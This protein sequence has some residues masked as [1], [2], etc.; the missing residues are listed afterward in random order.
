MSVGGS[1]GLL[2][3]STKKGNLDRKQKNG[4]DVSLSS[5][6]KGKGKATGMN[7]GSGISTNTSML[8][9]SSVGVAGKKGQSTHD[10]LLSVLNGEKEGKKE[11]VPLAWGMKA[12]SS[13]LTSSAQTQ[14]V[15]KKQDDGYSN[16]NRISND[17]SANASA[18]ASATSLG[19]GSGKS[20][21]TKI[22]Q[23]SSPKKEK[24]QSQSQLVSRSQIYDNGHVALK[25]SNGDG[26]GMRMQIKSGSSSTSIPASASASASTSI[27]NNAP[28]LVTEPVSMP[29]KAPTPSK[30]MST[31]LSSSLPHTYSNSKINANSNANG[32]TDHSNVN[33]NPPKEDQVEF[34][35]K[36]AKERAEKH[37]V[38]EERRVLAQKERA[39]L[40]LKE[41]EL[42]MKVHVQ[43]KDTLVSASP[44]SS[45]PSSQKVKLQSET[46]TQPQIKIQK[47]LYDP[48]RPYS[49]LVGGGGANNINPGNANAST[50]HSSAVPSAS[51]IVENDVSN[52]DFIGVSN[53]SAAP[54][55]IHINN[56][57]DRDRGSRSNAG[58]RML[59]DPKSGSMVAA[60]GAREKKITK[61]KTGR[62]TVTN[63][64][65][66]SERRNG[67]GY[68]NTSANAHSNVNTSTPTNGKNRD[69]DY[70]L[71]LEKDAHGSRKKSSRYRQREASRKAKRREDN[72]KAR[73]GTGAT[74]KAEDRTSKRGRTLPRTCGVLYKKD[75]KG[76]LISADG[77]EGDQGYGAHSVRGGRI[78]NPN[79]YS[80]MKRKGRNA[81]K[82]ARKSSVVT[83][84][85]EIRVPPDAYNHSNVGQHVHQH[86]GISSHADFEYNRGLNRSHFMRKNQQQQPVEDNATDH[87]VELPSSI[88]DVVTG[89]EKLDLF[90]GLDESPK[91]QASAAAWAPSEAVLALAAANAKKADQ[92]VYH[93]QD[94]DSHDGISD[95]GVLALNAMALVDNQSNNTDHEDG[96][97]SV[98]ASPSIGLGLGFDPSKNMDSLMMS[99]AMEGQVA[100]VDSNLSSFTLK[101]SSSSSKIS[102]NPFVSPNGLLG[103]TTWATPNSSNNLGSLSQWDLIGSATSDKGS[104]VQNTETSSAFLSLGVGGS[105]ATWGNGNGNAFSGFNGID[106]PSM[107]NS[108]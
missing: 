108:D 1:G 70:G 28:P 22:M 48:N 107:G 84:D 104:D 37:K 54:S 6:G 69:E 96:R 38:E 20:T 17:N 32:N 14:S 58:P 47:S 53:N 43:A 93:V 26:G 18:S 72:G 52:L 98:E 90:S 49:S 13:S 94:S 12:P 5:L 31:P 63:S 45:V 33:P 27:S 41:L 74:N 81:G 65:N 3:L 91:L 36:L 46:Q 7:I 76:H 87:S 82:L 21:S 16:S 68:S 75:S 80:A 77:C 30:S 11:F 57:E 39:A 2:L 106:G 4:E 64:S 85:T 40:R 42:K 71:D 60:P 97:N 19:S 105:Q 15:T 67:D 35:K 102:S 29:T 61:K 51:K 92:V 103:S 79:E 23:S 101:H 86:S 89:D 10:A 44:S 55:M 99:P 9:G 50:G 56:Y 88:L 66:S 62:N 78:R 8:T 59:F 83:S 24:Q 25:E 73:K 95:S 34:M 100:E